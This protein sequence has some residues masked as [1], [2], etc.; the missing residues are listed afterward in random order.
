[1]AR[2]DRETRSEGDDLRIFYVLQAV[3]SGFI[4]FA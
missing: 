1:M 2:G 4:M 3:T